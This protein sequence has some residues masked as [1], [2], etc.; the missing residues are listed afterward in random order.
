MFT[1]SLTRQEMEHE[2][3]GELV[4]IESGGGFQPPSPQLLQR[5][6]KIF[7]PIAA[8]IAAVMALGAY[9]FFSYEE[10][11]IATVP[12]GETAAVFV[13]VTPTPR[14]TPTPVPTSPPGEG[15]NP[16]SWAG[17][18]EEL[19]RNRCSS[20]HGLTAVGGLSL[21]SYA[22]ALKGG[23]SG[24][25]ILPGDPD[26]SVLVQIQSS[27]NHPGQLTIDEINQVIEWIKAGAVEK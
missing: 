20:C 14:P 6:K 9:F 4:Q 18:F 25:A 5:R 19:F 3:P 17:S 2:H 23:N 15:V 13:P 24:P 11:A 26:A 22:D 10:T 16:L 12:R 8:V 21:S 1:G 7:Y 27:G